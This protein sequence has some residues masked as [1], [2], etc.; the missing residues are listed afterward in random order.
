ML[1]LEK[2]TGKVKETAVEVKDW[3]NDHKEALFVCGAITGVIVGGIVLGRA[4]DK[5]YEK[6]WRDAKRALD[7][8][9]LDY[10][11]GPYKLM[12]FLEP[13]TGEMIGETVCHKN[14][15]DLFLEVK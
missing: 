2:I 13:K 9:R 4:Y 7:D 10:D 5:K 11:F 14:T 8:G 3:A 6:A 15:V 1:K 12:R